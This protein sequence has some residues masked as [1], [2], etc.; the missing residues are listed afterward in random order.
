MIE[1]GRWRVENVDM[2]IGHM[3]QVN[4]KTSDRK[5]L[6]YVQKQAKFECMGEQGDDG[7]HTITVAF[8]VKTVRHM[9][10]V[11]TSHM[12]TMVVISPMDRHV[13][14]VTMYLLDRKKCDP[15]FVAAL[16]PPP[17]RQ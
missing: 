17:D 14:Q 12:D 4:L 1:G 11:K 5:L 13:E 10:D 15:R 6:K 8:K 3:V 16:T 2:Q 9:F 7:D